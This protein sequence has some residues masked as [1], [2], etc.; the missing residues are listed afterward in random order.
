MVIMKMNKFMKKIIAGM[1]LT[2]VLMSLVACGN[3]KATETENSSKEETASEK[4]SSE[5]ET[6]MHLNRLRKTS[7]SIILKELVI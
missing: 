7:M 1:I 3:K 4:E 5:K 2:T 6:V